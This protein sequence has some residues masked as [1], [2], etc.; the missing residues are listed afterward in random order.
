MLERKLIV[1]HRRKIGIFTITTLN[2]GNRLQN[3]A[4][5]N[6][7][8]NLGFDVYTVPKKNRPVWIRKMI[9]NLN[10]LRGKCACWNR[11]NLLIKWCG[12]TAGDEHCK[13]AEKFDY[14]IAGSDQVWNPN[15]PFVTDR[16]FLSFVSREK[17]ISYAASIGISE[18]DEEQKRIFAPRFDMIKSLSVREDSAAEI[19]KECTG[20]KAEVVLDPTMLL[21]AEDWRKIAKMSRDSHKGKYIFVY[22]LGKKSER[23]IAYINK[24][25]EETGADVVE[26]CNIMN[27]ID[28]KNGPAEFVKYIMNAENVVT[29]SFHC[30]VFSILFHKQFVAFD[31]E[32]FE[33]NGVMSSRLR[34]L[35]SVFGF[36]N[37]LISGDTPI[38]PEITE[39]NFEK[40]DSVLA[41]KRKD[42]LEFL[43][44]SLDVNG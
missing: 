31:R 43:K 6:V 8:E 13:K 16:Y 20:R 15:F 22:F 18:F 1:N 19:I 9:M 4:L 34:Y 21:D 17:R 40:A 42:S 14:F 30:C 39:E 23:C 29:D 25:K 10:I 7:L 28:D 36:E 41:T 35:F 27:K 11:F 24:L 26:I 44:A 32:S 3:Y 2:Y 5:Q 38:P 12:F 33:N 37:R